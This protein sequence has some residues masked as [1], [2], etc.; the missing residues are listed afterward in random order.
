MIPYLGAKVAV[1]K[2]WYLLKPRTLWMGHAFL[3]T[4]GIKTESLGIREV[5][6]DGA[7]EETRTLDVYLG[8][9]MFYSG[10]CWAL[11]VCCQFWPYILMLATLA[12]QNVFIQYHR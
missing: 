4:A 10:G 2:C 7:G 3:D 11:T 12:L 8:K 5:R 9:V 1:W 6:R